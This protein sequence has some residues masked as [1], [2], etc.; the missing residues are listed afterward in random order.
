METR[1]V[2]RLSRSPWARYTVA[3]VAPVLALLIRAAIIP[4]LGDRSPYLTFLVATAASATYGGYGAGALS[5]LLG[6]LL[7]GLFAVPQFGS[8]ALADAHDYGALA[9]FIVTSAVV[10]YL[11]GRLIDSTLREHALRIL[12]QSTLV[13]IGDAVISTDEEKCVR[14]MNPVAESLTGWTE[15]E[16]K[17]RPIDE[18]FRIVEEGADTPA[19]NPMDS[20]FTTG[21]AASFAQ[22]TE[23]LSKTGKR[24]A[25][26]D[27]G[28]PIFDDRGRIAG[29]VL[30][31]RDITAR[32]RAERELVAGERRARTIL[33]SISDGFILLDHQWRHAQMNSTAERL[34]GVPAGSLI[35][36]NHWEQY[37]ALVGT[38]VETLYRKAV[39][40][41]EAVHLENFYEPWDRWFDI[42]A[43]PSVEGLALYFRDITERKRSEAAA[44][45]ANEDLKQFT[46]AATHDVREPL[47]MIMVY[48]D[49]L[50][51]GL[52]QHLDE[53]AK[54]FMTHVVNGAQRISRL[55]EGLGEFSRVGEMDTAEPSTV[56][57]EAAL[58][59]ALDDLQIAI[60]E[61]GASISSDPLPPVVADHTHVCQ[62]F[63]N[64]IGNS[65]KYTKPDSPAKIHVSA[66]REG[67]LCVF[68]VKDNG[69][70]I[71]PQHQT[72]I[73]LPFKRLHGAEIAGAGIGLATCQRIVERHG[74]SLWVESE[75]GEGATFYFSL[76]AAES[77]VH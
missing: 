58:R 36:K 54:T 25:I 42:S 30:V 15:A 7:G 22:P 11:G 26:D 59:E 77:P 47:R 24:I 33:E 73:F 51:R 53:Q 29:A 18:V 9:L 62:L 20:I 44:R 19:K 70:G 38:H 23:L 16:A 41:G 5:T 45:R 72:R 57:A 1:L 66:H 28:A 56:N 21:A 12:C 10:S 64:L 76:P 37:P 8:I 68:A 3:V 67:S 48:V 69:I 35:G 2:K 46:F 74:G 61:A 31:F 40:D 49:M 32:R 55:I 65:L 27:S 43:Y 71:A 50:Q 39:A 75:E 14:L 34:L 52:G 13:S 4:V 63:Q 60:A 6:A 17:G